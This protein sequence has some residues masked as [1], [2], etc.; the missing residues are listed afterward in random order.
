MDRGLDG[1]TDVFVPARRNPGTV[2][3]CVQVCVYACVRL[4]IVHNSLSQ[5]FSVRCVWPT[6][7]LT[8]LAAWLVWLRSI[9][10]P[11]S[12]RT[13]LWLMDRVCV[14]ERERGEHW[15]GG[16]MGLGCGGWT[17][18]LRSFSCDRPLAFI[19]SALKVNSLHSHFTLAGKWKGGKKKRWVGWG[20]EEVEKGSSLTVRRKDGT[21]KGGSWGVR[22]GEIRKAVGWWADGEKK[23]TKADQM[24]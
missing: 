13:F 7:P 10:A 6:I 20:E 16:W 18:P 23:W 19:L 9:M 5:R 14:W 11:V 21:E 1:I 24:L 17:G 15:C 12:L 22:G 3:V 4:G 2:L 8:T